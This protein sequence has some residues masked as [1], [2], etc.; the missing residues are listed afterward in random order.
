MHREKVRVPAQRLL[1]LVRADAPWAR[2]YAAGFLCHF[3]LDSRCHAYVEEKVWTEGLSHAGMEGELD[4]AL[5][6][7]DRRDPFRAP[8]LDQ[9]SLPQGLA[10]TA[11]ALYPGLTPSQFAQGCRSFRRI[12]RLQARLAGTRAHATVDRLGA[13]WQ[14]FAKMQGVVLAPEPDPRYAE[15][16]AVLMELLEGEAAPTARAV[17]RFFAAVARDGALDGWY[18]R[19]FGGTWRPGQS[20]AVAR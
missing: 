12:S 16:T 13:R 2:G 4:R 8:A 3:A 14:R 10:E 20:S 11:A 18:D 1:E 9:L 15:S 5:M 7:R 19:P 17:S 6:L